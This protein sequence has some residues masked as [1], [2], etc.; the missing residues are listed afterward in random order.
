MAEAT[1][2]ERN[3]NESVVP[4]PIPEIKSRPLEVNEAIA[5]LPLTG[6]KVQK[7]KPKPIA[8]ARTLS[9]RQGRTIMRMKEKARQQR[10]ADQFLKGNVPYVVP[11]NSENF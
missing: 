2:V 8:V 7:V 1:E 9:R 10:Q 5:Q 6:I 3:V 4:A 11:L